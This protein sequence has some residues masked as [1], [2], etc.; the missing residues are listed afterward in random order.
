MY[1]ELGD[2]NTPRIFGVA[3]AATAIG[4][5]VR[6]FSWLVPNDV[7]TDSL[8]TQLSLQCACTAFKASKT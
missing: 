2:P 1:A 3:I 4:L 6:A 8:V 5:I 7:R